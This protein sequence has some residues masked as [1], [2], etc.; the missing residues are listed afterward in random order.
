MTGASNSFEKNE[1][2]KGFLPNLIW[3]LKGFVY[4]CWSREYY[5]FSIKKRFLHAALF[6]LVFMFAFSSI[7]TVKFASSL[8][9]IG[10]EINGAYE[11]GEFPN[12]YIE[13]GIARTDGK[14][15]FIFTN[16]RTV[17]EIDT[18]GQ[19]QSIDTNLYSEGI[20]LTRDEVHFVSD[21]GYREFPLTELNDAF[22]N[23][24]ILD[25]TNV[26][27][28]WNQV[29]IIIILFVLFGG[30][31]FNLLIR[32]LAIV[33][34]GLLVWG[35]ISIKITGIGFNPIL[36]TGIYANVPASYFFLLSKFIGLSF[37]GLRPLLLIAI[38]L[39]VALMVFEK[40][41]ISLEP[42]GVNVPPDN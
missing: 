4:P 3:L 34:L 37:C 31:I 38:W 21:E 2:K 39:L 6:F 5:R 19:T 14:E 28:F 16:N 8:R 42:E 25:K 23:P 7:T 9:T 12:I 18:S 17:I 29:K 24:I 15:R 22:G 32:F 11:R 36:I 26:L 13:N 30:Y 1:S 10:K 27:N 41:E 40:D 35:I 20:L 33:L